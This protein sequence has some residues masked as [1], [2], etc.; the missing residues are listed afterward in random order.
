M[1]VSSRL[2]VAGAAAIDEHERRIRSRQLVRHADAQVMRPDRPTGEGF[3]VP[4]E[5]SGAHDRRHSLTIE[6]LLRCE[7]Q[8]VEHVVGL[9]VRPDDVPTEVRIRR[10]HVVIQR[11]AVASAHEQHGQGQQAG[12]SSDA[13]HFSSGEELDVTD[14]RAI[15]PAF[16]RVFTFDNSVRS[17]FV[18]S[19]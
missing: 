16:R 10:A 13:R 2:P 5:D 9:G 8:N 6:P 7:V 14:P 15:S 1:A 18:V 17:Y 4:T 3:Y 11:S 12:S 19:L